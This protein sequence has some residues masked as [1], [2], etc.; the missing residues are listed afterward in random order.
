MN[1]LYTFIIYLNNIYYP[2]NLHIYKNEIIPNTL[3]YSDILYFIK[4]W[5][6]KEYIFIFKFL[7]EYYFLIFFFSYKVR[8]KFVLYYTFSKF[9]NILDGSINSNDFND[10]MEKIIYTGQTYYFSK[11]NMK[12]L[13]IVKYPITKI[14]N[15]FFIINII[16]NFIELSLY[17]NYNS[18][19]FEYFS[20]YLNYCSFIFCFYLF[21]CRIYSI[22]ILKIFKFIILLILDNTV[23]YIITKS[24]YF[25]VRNIVLNF[26]FNHNNF[27]IKSNKFCDVFLR[28][29]K[30]IVVD[31]SRF[32]SPV[33]GLLI[34]SSNIQ[35]NY[36]LINKQMI[37]FKKILNKN[38]TLT[39]DYFYSIYYLTYK[40]YHYVHSP[41][42]C[43][44]ID[45][46]VIDGSYHWMENS[47][48]FG[49]KFLGNNYRHVFQIIDSNG[50]E[51][52]LIMIASIIAGTIVHDINIPASIKKGDMIAHFD[53]GS[54]VIFISKH[55]MKSEFSLHKRVSVCK[56]IT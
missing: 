5:L 11:K 50:N 46:F 2:K 12:F 38:I 53:I 15:N 17:F 25:S 9:E 41:F 49:C 48:E 7:Y 19:S 31:E 40:D 36:L 3:K 54:M 44:I 27:N 24:K 42:D 35:N 6:C 52:F 22:N 4:L 43:N 56:T 45:F 21:V 14:I 23:S 10:T 33:D 34:Q 30:K 51:C 28:L 37:D 8:C 55:E 32:V 1:I 13:N 16:A 18:Y 29:Y 47:I 20:Y 26:D 39:D